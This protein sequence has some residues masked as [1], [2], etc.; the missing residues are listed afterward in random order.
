MIYNYDK[1]RPFLIKFKF[2]NIS[3]VF[4]D[5]DIVTV[6]VTLFSVEI[7]EFPTENKYIT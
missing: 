3:F 7:D 5:I 1:L 6:K 2:V 4:P